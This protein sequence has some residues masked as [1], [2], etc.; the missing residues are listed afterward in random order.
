MIRALMAAVVLTLALAAPVSAASPNYGDYT[1]MFGR[2]AGQVWADGV[3]ASQWAWK[4]LSANESEISWG[5]PAAWPPDGGEDFVRDGD[6]V[7][8]NGYFDHDHNSFNTQRVTAEYIGDANCGNLQAIPSNGGRQHYARWTIP[9]EAYCLKATGTITVGANGAVVHF[10]HDQIWYPP[11]PCSSN[12]YLGAHTC[13]RQHERWSDDNAHPF[14]L[15]LER[16]QYIAQSLGMAFHIDHTYDRTW[17]PGHAPWR[18]DLRYT[19]T[20]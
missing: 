8:L 19:W 1:L 7:L 6:W 17:V 20:W 18:A 16:D 12:S 9:A 14:S 10:Q 11:A 4:P 2:N 5:D 13:I 3:A 15:S